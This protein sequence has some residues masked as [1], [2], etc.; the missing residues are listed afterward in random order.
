MIEE[1]ISEMVGH[2]QVLPYSFLIM[3]VFAGYN[4]SPATDE[5]V[6]YFIQT[7]CRRRGIPSPVPES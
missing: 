5:V 7:P 3:R 4:F 1:F 2:D 6:E